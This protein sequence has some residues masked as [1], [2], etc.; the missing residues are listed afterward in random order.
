MPALDHRV[1][2]AAFQLSADAVAFVG[3]DDHVIESNPA[4]DQL[5]GSGEVPTSPLPKLFVEAERFRVAALL[6]EARRWSESSTTATAEVDGV[7]VQL[8]LSASQFVPRGGERLLLV[9]A[10]SARGR[11]AAERLHEAG[12]MA[13]HACNQ[14]TTWDQLARNAERV[15]RQVLPSASGSARLRKVP[16]GWSI[17]SA[18]GVLGAWKEAGGFPEAKLWDG[19]AEG[20]EAVLFADV[21][22]ELRGEE[23]RLEKALPAASLLVSPIVVGEHV[24]S[25]F[26]VTGSAVAAFTLDDVRCMEIVT[27][28]MASAIARLEA[29]EALAAS[30]RQLTVA[31]EENVALLARVRR[32]NAELED[33]AL[34]TTHDLREP[35]RGVASL[36]ELLAGEAAASAETRDLALRLRD[37]S[38]RLKEHIRALHEFH[39]IARDPGRR[40][41]V[42]LDRVLREV[43]EEVGDAEV[44]R[45][46]GSVR[47]RGDPAR[48]RRALVDVLRHAASRARRPMKVELVEA[49]DVV[50]S[51]A[52][53]EGVSG[54]AAEVAFHVVGQADS[55][56]LARRIALQHGGALEFAPDPA[57]LVLRLPRA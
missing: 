8:D 56:A 14:A 36:A 46:G 15:V 28:E 48:L 23:P 52:L 22:F 9:R 50:V 25:L 54:R 45:D 6:R 38:I 10:R 11:L 3:A 2:E 31:F 17:T 19:L 29:Y 37:S 42:E 51:L 35:L 57:R 40:E 20:R 32:L 41:M 1:Y 34:W 53:L 49:E 33:F 30:H 13:A 5:L 39:E 47:V 43:V 24:G 27:R 4:F 12:V 26:L 18:S 7:A 21:A 55:L 16:D 44:L